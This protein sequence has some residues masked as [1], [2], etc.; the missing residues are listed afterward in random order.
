[1]KSH[2]IEF[3]R[4]DLVVRITRCPAEEPGKSPSVEIEVESSGLPWSFV[5]F[6]REPQLFAFKEML[7]EYIETFRSMKDDAGGS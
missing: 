4:D 1:M 7:E 2:T 6:D 3:T 5:W